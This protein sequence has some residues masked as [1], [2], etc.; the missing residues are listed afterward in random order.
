MIMSS[1]RT[2][3]RTLSL[4]GVMVALAVGTANAGE[5]PADKVVTSGQGQQAGA[6]M[7]KGV[8]DNVLGAID[9]AKE[10]IGVTKGG[11]KVYPKDIW[12][13]TKEI[14]AFVR[15]SISKK[16]FNTKYADVFT[17]NPTWNEV[18]VSSSESYPWDD[19]STY[20]RNPPF[21]EGM[22]EE[23]P[24]IGLIRGARCLAQFGDSVT[25]DHISPAGS[26]AEDSPAGRWLI[27]HGVPKREFN[28][29]GS[30][31]GNHEVMMRGTF[32]NVRVRNR[33]A[34]D[35]SG[36]IPEGGLTRDF[37]RENGDPWGAPVD[38]IYDAAMRYRERG[39]PLVVLAGKDYGMGSSRDWAA[40]G[41]MLLGVR[42]V[43]A[44]SF[45]RIHRSNL[46]FM[47]VL[48]L[49][50]SRGE[51]AESLGLDGSETFDILLPETPAPRSEVEVVARSADGAETR[52]TCTT[53]IDTPIEV[54][55]YRNGGILQT[56][57]R[58]KLKE[59]RQGGGG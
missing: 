44:E 22:T 4:A 10:P 19:A 58:K 31:R 13:G 23:A 52:F 25:T 45:E 7:P 34:R 38:W 46:V 2:A 3:R 59:A 18:P 51:N 26:I 42:A 56:V 57:I 11:L 15:K 29:Y 1:S 54:E 20:I 17:G 14:A 28:S 30:R 47:G 41:T 12:P 48:P 36:R 35:A 55:Y 27:E 8:T 16:M 39:V 40:K 53:R 50:F 32:A 43:I 6:S 9:L 24:G 33:L 49:V 5:C 37:T 21:F